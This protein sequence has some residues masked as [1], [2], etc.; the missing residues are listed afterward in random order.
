MRATIDPEAYL[1]LKAEINGLAASTLVDS[2][3]TGIFMHPT[4]ARE[5]KAEVRPKLIPREVRLIDGRAINSGLI[6]QEVTVDIQ[7]GSHKEKL[8]ADITNT[9]HYACILGTP[10]LSRHDPTIRWSRNEVIFDSEYCQTTCLKIP[11][12][13]RA[14]NKGYEQVEEHTGEDR[15]SKVQIEDRGRTNGLRKKGGF[16][17]TAPAFVPGKNRVTGTKSTRLSTPKHAI[18]SAAAFRLSV[19]GAEIF[20]VEISD[21]PE[22]Q[23]N[24]KSV[25]QQIPEEYQDLRGAFSEQASNELPDHGPLDMKIEFKEGEEPRNTGLRPMSP[26]EL[27]ELRR[28]LEENLG[29]GWIRRS[30]SPVS[31]PIVFARK[32]DGSIR[33]CVDYRNLN[34][35]TVRNRYPLPLIPELTDRLV[36]A[37]IFSKLD[38]RQAY[39]RV[40]MAAGHEFKTAFKTRYGLFEYLVMPFGLTNAPAQFQAHMQCI[41]HDLLDISVVIYLDDILIFSKT[42]EEHRLVV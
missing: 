18:V 36:G 10:W 31:A 9:G 14:C 23:G 2:G 20:S 1:T 4:F 12:Q 26:V 37:K 15:A 32:K 38:V 16:S 41:F 40:R 35:V 33:V 34:R 21:V 22:V 27:E 24:K 13:P 39:H 8:V 25:E 6:T 30:K 3:A 11:T 17:S 7:V 29:K 28:Y 19:Q 5:C 42:L